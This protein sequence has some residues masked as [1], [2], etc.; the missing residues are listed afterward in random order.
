[1]KQGKIW[2][3]TE[4]V[5]LTPLIEVHRLIINP[6]A[7]CSWHK[8]ERKSNMFLVLSGAL[9]IEVRKNDYALTDKTV[10][11]AGEV[12]TVPPGEFHR[13][14]TDEKGCGI[15]E[16]FEIYYPEPIGKDIVRESVGGLTEIDEPVSTE[17]VPDDYTP[18]F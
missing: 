6:G 1:M 9:T 15:T 17:L 12:T 11:E 13:F 14:V 7:H 18:K 4:L 2:G 16:A 10:L 3:S 8:H 5:L